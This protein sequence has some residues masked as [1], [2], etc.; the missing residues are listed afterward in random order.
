[1]VDL[2]ASR[3]EAIGRREAKKWGLFLSCYFWVISLCIFR[4]WCWNHWC[5]ANQICICTYWYVTQSRVHGVQQVIAIR[6]V[7]SGDFDSGSWLAMQVFDSYCHLYS[8]PHHSLPRELVS[9]SEAAADAR[10][11]PILQ[12]FVLGHTTKTKWQKQSCRGKTKSKPHILVSGPS[13]EHRDK[14]MA[15]WRKKIIGFTEYSWVSGYLEIIVNRGQDHLWGRS[16][17]ISR[18]QT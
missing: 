12:C 9:A 14:L 2:H 11:L 1:M 15:L 18:G 7:C 16:M 8:L 5:V 10:F 3:F 6:D 4:I 17:S 13:L